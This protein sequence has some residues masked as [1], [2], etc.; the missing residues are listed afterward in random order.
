MIVFASPVTYTVGV[1]ILY[2]QNHFWETQL[3]VV[4]CSVEITDNHALVTSVCFEHLLHP[5]ILRTEKNRLQQTK[6]FQYSL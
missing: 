6:S 3:S 4:L 1:E 5:K 2:Y